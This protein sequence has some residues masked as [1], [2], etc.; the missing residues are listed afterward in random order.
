MPTAKTLVTAAT[1]YVLSFLRKF[2]AFN[3]TLQLQLCF[4]FF[5]QVQCF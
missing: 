2:N 1:D 5:T 3:R 4:E